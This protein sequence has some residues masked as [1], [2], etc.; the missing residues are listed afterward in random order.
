M[1][2]FTEDLLTLCR[3]NLMEE[4]VIDSVSPDRDATL[5]AIDWKKRN[6]VNRLIRDEPQNDIQAAAGGFTQVAAEG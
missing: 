2:N 5:T 4:T 1:D 6:L 3:L